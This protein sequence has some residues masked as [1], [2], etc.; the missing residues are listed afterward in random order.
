MSDG[1]VINLLTFFPFT[2]KGCLNGS[3]IRVINRFIDNTWE[4]REFFPPKLKN[5]HRYA[6]KLGIQQSAPA[7]ERIMKR[8]HTYEYV[9]SDIEIA[10]EFARIFNFTN[11]FIFDNWWGEVYENESGDYNLGKLLRKEI[12]YVVGWHFLNLIKSKFLDYTQPYYFVPFIIIV[13]SGTPYTSLENLMRCFTPSLWASFIA[14]CSLFYIIFFII[15]YFIK[16][17]S[18]PIMHFDVLLIII[19]GESTSKHYPTRNSIR[20]IVMT[21]I[22]FCFIIRT[23][24]VSEMFNLL[25]SGSNNRDIDSLDD[26]REQKYTLFTPSFIESYISLTELKYDRKYIKI[27]ENF[28]DENRIKQVFDPSFRGAFVEPLDIVIRANKNSSTPYNILSQPLSMTPVVIYFQKNSYLRNIFDEKLQHLHQAGLI[29]LWISQQ[30]K[31]KTVRNNV[32]AGNKEP[33]VLSLNQLSAAF[34]ICIGGILLSLIV[35]V[36]E[37]YYIRLKKKKFNRDVARKQVRW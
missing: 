24:Y 8:D 37:I 12:D 35:F 7:A 36:A 17:Q 10:D 26:L 11:N 29:D 21:F 4:T 18:L 33:K 16:R 2:N 19:L 22:I 1:N 9:G 20:L 27:L 25:Q 13:P 15:N 32:E 30:W 34:T 3:N 6:L 31:S 28:D 14:S 5:F 23:V